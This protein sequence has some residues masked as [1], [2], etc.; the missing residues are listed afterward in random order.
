MVEKMGDVGVVVGVVR[1]V[2][3]N[4]VVNTVAC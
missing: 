3:S 4:G 2:E 1:L